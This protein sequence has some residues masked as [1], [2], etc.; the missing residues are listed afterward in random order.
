MAKYEVN[1]SQLLDAAIVLGSV[2]GDL[3]QL[4][5]RMDGIFAAIPRSVTDTR[6]QA[7]AVSGAIEDLSVVGNKLRSTLE[8]A[9]EIYS[10]AEKSEMGSFDGTH[11][12]PRE[13][14]GL[15]PPIAPRNSGVLF[16]SN[17]VLPKWLQVALLRYEQRE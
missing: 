2:S 17:L 1:T 8:D 4:R 5:V 7:S 11:Q 10:Q 13:I 16:K 12:L 15:L 6:P 9:A 14:T 3:K